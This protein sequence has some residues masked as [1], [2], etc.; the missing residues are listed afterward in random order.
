LV[1][2]LAMVFSLMMAVLVASAL[3]VSA[4]EMRMAGNAGSRM[5]ALEM[6]DSII[7]RIL[8]QPDSFPL[9]SEPGLLPCPENAATTTCGQAF[10]SS[11]R[12][13]AYSVSRLAPEFRDDFPLREA[14]SRVSGVD[15]FNIALFEVAVTV[16][17]R[18][19]RS[20][21]AHVVQGVAVRVPA[22]GE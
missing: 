19:G 16:G 17:R 21:R 18:A 4:L 5:L 12:D 20:G 2:L 1:L 9:S 10:S 11:E 13:A 15:H 14:E 6:A 3:R 8:Q 22:V 7:T